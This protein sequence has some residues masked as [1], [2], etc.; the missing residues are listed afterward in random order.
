MKKLMH[1]NLSE[2]MFA[3]A[4][5]LERFPDDRHTFALPGE[6]PFFIEGRDEVLKFAKGLRV[7][8]LERRKLELSQW[9]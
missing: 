5:Y 6:E 1:G 3:Q 4:D 2:I 9:N 7:M 8:A